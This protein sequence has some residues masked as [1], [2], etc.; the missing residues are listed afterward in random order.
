MMRREVAVIRRIPFA[1][2]A[3]A[4]ASPAWAANKDIERLQIQVADL[5]RQLY[6]L[7]RMAEESQAEVRRLN[8]ALADQNDLLKRQLESRRVQDE[9]L[10]SSLRDIT[11]RLS[12]LGERVQALSVAPPAAA[13]L[14]AANPVAPEPGPPGTLP[15]PAAPAGPPPRELYSQAYADYARGN[16][17]VAI[18]GFTQ[19]QRH[20]AAANDLIDNAQYWIGE[21]YYGKKAYAE[22]ITAWDALFRDYPSSDKLPD[23]HVKKGMALEKMARRRDALREYR[24]VMDRY[25]NSPAARIARDRLNP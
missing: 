12:E 10:Q 18:Q 11:D 25:P 4:L 3:L 15:A 23:A 13:P 9:Q 22:A 8:E 21:S 16:Y 14:A 24:L 6:D 20:P 17:D 2:L 7:V 19:Y 5:Q 1:L